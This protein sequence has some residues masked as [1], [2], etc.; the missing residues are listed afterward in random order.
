MQKECVICGDMFEA[1]RNT[2]QYC[3][4]CQK[5]SS[6]ARK[7]MAYAIIVNKK[8]AGDYEKVKDKTCE[9]CGKEFKTIR[10]QKFCCDTCEKRYK[11]ETNTCQY[12]GK[13]LYPEVEYLGGAVHPACKEPA[14]REWALRKGW[15]RNCKH[16]GKEYYAKNDGQSFCCRECS[17]EYQKSHPQEYIRTM[18]K[19]ET[20]KQYRC[21]VCKK[22]FNAK[23]N[24]VFENSERMTVCSDE[25]KKIAERKYCEYLIKKKIEEA[26]AAEEERKKEIEQN[27]LCASCHTKY[28]DCEWMCSKFKIKPEGAKYKNSKVI[29]CPKYTC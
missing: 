20:E 21:Y 9:Y 4:K 25:C 8:H 7:K 13:L 24:S 29:E 27:G 17:R 5:N 10:Q 11:I 1:I 12:C 16:C 3:D 18:L 23:I 14:Y 26:K 22:I 6:K 28:S 2:R 15:V 19:A